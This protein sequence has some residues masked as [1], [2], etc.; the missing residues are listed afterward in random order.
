MWYIYCFTQRC[1]AQLIHQNKIMWQVAQT[2]MISVSYEKKGNKTVEWNLKLLQLHEKYFSIIFP[3][4]K[5][6]QSSKLTLILMLILSNF[7]RKNINTFAVDLDF[8]YCNWCVWMLCLL[9]LH[10]CSVQMNNSPD[11]QFTIPSFI[12]VQVIH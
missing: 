12:R 10:H 4:L 11:Q 7:K 9:C 1:F 5:N 3:L 2:R 6:F 8:Y